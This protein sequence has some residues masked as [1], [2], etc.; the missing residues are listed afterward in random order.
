[1]SIIYF[2]VGLLASVIGALAGIGGGII[3]KPSLDLLG[4]F[5][6][7]TIGILSSAT[8]LMMATVSLASSATHGMRIQKRTSLTLAAGS[9]AGGLTGQFGFDFF[10]EKV[11][12]DKPVLLVQSGSLAILMLVIYFLVK[13]KS[14]LNTYQLHQLAAIFAIGFGLGIIGAF[15][16]IGGGPL[17]IA[18]LTLLFSMHAKEAAVNSIFIIFF[19]QLASLI[20]AFGGNGFAP[21]DFS[22]LLY[23]LAGGALGGFAGSWLSDKVREE[24]IDKFFQILILVIFFLN[25]F[26]I[27]KLVG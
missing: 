9:I 20:L 1:M 27:Y 12:D 23:M 19:S 18:I 4:N 22:M 16:G 26:N 10:L 8:V 6:A 17:N 5:D 2:L 7:A 11:G 14:R 21:Y 15:L 3:I 25:I 13:F 24:T